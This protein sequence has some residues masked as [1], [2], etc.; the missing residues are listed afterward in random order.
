MTYSILQ[1]SIHLCCVAL[2][3]FALSSLKFEKFC[4]VRNPYKVRVLLILLSLG[5]GYLS[6]QLLLA[7][8]LFN[9]L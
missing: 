4:D 2:S 6:A 3:F 7:L 9:G 1:I 8:T 5:L